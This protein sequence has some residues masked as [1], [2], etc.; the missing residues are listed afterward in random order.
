[1]AVRHREGVVVS[2][3]AMPRLSGVESRGETGALSLSH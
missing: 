1:M 2:S 3:M